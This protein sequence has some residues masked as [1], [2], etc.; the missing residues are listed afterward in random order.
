MWW[1]KQRLTPPLTGPA[2]KLAQ[3]ASL[4]SETPINMMLR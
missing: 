3:E 2:I 1:S 4:E